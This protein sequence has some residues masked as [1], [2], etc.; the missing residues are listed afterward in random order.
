MLRSRHHLR[1]FIKLVL[2]DVYCVNGC[3]SSRLGYV[4]VVIVYTHNGD[5]TPQKKVYCCSCLES[6]YD[7]SE[8]YLL[9]QS[10]Y[11]MSYHVFSSL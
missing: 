6:N 2:W 7:C 10:L 3:W 11:R 5:D 9:V 4:G 1:G 8:V